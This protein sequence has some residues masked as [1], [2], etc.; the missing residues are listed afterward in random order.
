MDDRYSLE[1]LILTFKDAA[2]KGAQMN[3]R[4]RERFIENNPGEPVPEWF[5]PTFCINTALALMC[6]EI[7]TLRKS[8]DHNP[9]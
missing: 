2:V 1:K 9:C 7:L 4:E 3:E 8:N 6:E 5:N